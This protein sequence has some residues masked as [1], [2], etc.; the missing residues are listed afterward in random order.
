MNPL[1]RVENLSKHY[2][3]NRKL[4]YALHPLNLDIYSGETL[5][6]IG[7][8]GCGKSTLGKLILKLIPSSSGKVYFNGMDI[9]DFSHRHM[10]EQ[11]KHM[12]MIFQNSGTALDPCM[13]I[14]DIL[15][16]PYEIHFRKMSENE[17]LKHVLNQLKT[18]GMEAYHLDR[19]PHELSGGQKQRIGIARALAVKPTF[20]VC[21]EPLSAL[22]AST[23][24]QILE[25]LIKL[26]KDQKMTY[27]L[28][29][30]Q[31]REIK[32]IAHRVA[33]MYEGRLVELSP[34]PFFFQ[35]PLHPYSLSLLLASPQPDPK[36]ERSKISLPAVKEVCSSTH[37]Q[38]GCPFQ[39]RCPYAKA[40]CCRIVPPLQEIHKGSFVACHYPQKS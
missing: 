13:K 12:Q 3:I 2:K 25:L 35:N 15:Y 31:L 32:K 38:V 34:A 16:E 6:L 20:I 11:R 5:G 33:V 37:S 7:E 22:D 26:Q 17:K 14:Q 40:I 21:D 28:I 8:S 29:S 30:H 1:L 23:Q 4:L 9:S 27:L 10:K 24:S 19:Y 39:E 36:I 18:V